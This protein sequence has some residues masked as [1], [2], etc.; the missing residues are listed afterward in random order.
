MPVILKPETLPAWLGEDSADAA[1]LKGMLR[2]YPSE[3]MT[4]WSVSQRVGSVK[5]NDAS[6]I[7]PIAALL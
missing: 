6:L 2:P 3:E 7:E 4:C 5:N 1:R